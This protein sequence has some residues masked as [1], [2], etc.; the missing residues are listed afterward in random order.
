[1]FMLATFYFSLFSLMKCTGIYTWKCWA[2]AH[3]DGIWGR[4]ASVLTSSLDGAEWSA[5]LPGR[6]TVALHLSGRW[7]S[8]SP[9]KS[10]NWACSS[11]HSFRIVLYTGCGIQNIT[12]QCISCFHVLLV[13]HICPISPQIKL[14]NLK[15]WRCRWPVL[16][17]LIHSLSSETII[18]VRFR[19]AGKR[20]GTVIKYVVSNKCLIGPRSRMHMLTCRAAT[21]LSFVTV[22][23]ES[24][25]RLYDC[26]TTK[27]SERR[28]WSYNIKS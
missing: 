8:G 15:V 2:C 3:H 14:L 13:Y 11:Y 27:T 21:F 1:M 10:V 20:W 16:W 17:T 23:G 22:V 9:I 28:P 24:V 18:E 6:C 19:C 12:E 26:V 7:F 5:L 25:L 4:G